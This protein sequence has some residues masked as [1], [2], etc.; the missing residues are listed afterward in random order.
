MSKDAYGHRRVGGVNAGSVRGGAR[1]ARS[2]GACPLKVLA[3]ATFSA[4][5]TESTAQSSIST[6]YVNE[7]KDDTCDAAPGEFHIDLG[8][9]IPWS[10]YT[11]NS[12]AG[13]H[14]FAKIYDSIS[15]G[16]GHPATFFDL[17]TKY[18][19]DLDSLNS[20]LN[21]T[22]GTLPPIPPPNSWSILP[23]GNANGP[24]N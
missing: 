12:A 3:V 6:Y 21:S 18:G 8:G 4:L 9:F 19:L 2:R 14:A 16:T 11:E 22:L 17:M 23:F 20:E 13:G 5:T 24:T 15:W 7:G 10:R 1:P